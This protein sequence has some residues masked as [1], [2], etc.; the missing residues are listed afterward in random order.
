MFSFFSISCLFLFVFSYD[1]SISSLLS[2]VQEVIADVC[3][4]FFLPNIL[5][6]FYGIV[7]RIS[8]FDF[9]GDG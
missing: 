3:H 8:G 7:Y 5:A 2:I 1:A 9:Y 6:L 4:L